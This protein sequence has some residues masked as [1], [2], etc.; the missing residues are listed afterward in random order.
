MATAHG[1]QRVYNF[2]NA[3]LHKS[4]IGQ[5]AF[6]GPFMTLGT[7]D[8]EY[9]IEDNQILDEAISENYRPNTEV[10]PIFIQIVNNLSDFSRSIPGVTA[11]TY[12]HEMEKGLKKGAVILVDKATQELYCAPF[13]TLLNLGNQFLQRGEIVS[14]LFKYRRPA[15]KTWKDQNRLQGSDLMK[16]LAEKLTQY[17]LE[18]EL[19]SPW[20]EEYFR[21]S[22]THT[23][24]A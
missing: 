23:T 9:E 2:G 10:L 11:N 17:S 1:H 5:A 22:E 19:L 3:C 8:L 15:L 18:E 13:K 14:V 4:V 24:L 20:G 21:A 6:G 12:K 16:K 7:S